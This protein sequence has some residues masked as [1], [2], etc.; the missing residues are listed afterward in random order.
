MNVRT[1]DLAEM[2]SWNQ[3]EK[4]KTYYDVD[5][6]CNMIGTS[7]TTWEKEDSSGLLEASGIS[8]DPDADGLIEPDP[9]AEKSN[10]IGAKKSK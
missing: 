8:T 6:K 7:A 5:N 9:L 2:A 1:K 4:G 10:V 3:I